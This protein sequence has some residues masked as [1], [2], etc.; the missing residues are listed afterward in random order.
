MILNEEI[1][2][3]Y[4]RKEGGA[5]V[6][7]PDLNKM[8]AIVQGVFST[9]NVS[10]G[11]GKEITLATIRNILSDANVS[12]TPD[13]ICDLVAELVGRGLINPVLQVID[14]GEH[15]RLTPGED[16]TSLPEILSGKEPCAGPNSGD[17]LHPS[18]IFISYEII[19]QPVKYEYN[20]ARVKILCVVIAAVLCVIFALSYVS[21][22]VSLTLH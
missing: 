1:A 4:E 5:F 14:G 16:Y 7:N 18:Q 3:A 6:P 21:E 10:E 8:V 19:P 13:L 17:I 12:L 15:H 20:M 11:E 9:M 2:R 22:H